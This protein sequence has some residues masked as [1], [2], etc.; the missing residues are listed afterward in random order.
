MPVLLVRVRS[1]GVTVTRRRPHVVILRTAAGE[2]V[3]AALSRRLGR[4]ARVRDLREL[5]MHALEEALIALTEE[6]A[7]P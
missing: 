1:V 6:E 7:T 3:L 5:C 4:R 2:E